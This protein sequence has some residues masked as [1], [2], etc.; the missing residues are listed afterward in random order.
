M[1]E[2]PRCKIDMKRIDFQAETVLPSGRTLPRLVWRCPC[3][4]MDTAPA[5]RP[6]VFPARQTVAAAYRSA[7]AAPAVVQLDLFADDPIPADF[8]RLLRSGSSP[9]LSAK[10]LTVLTVEQDALVRR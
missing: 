2:C 3:C 4:L 10:V 5:E 7:A 9:S 8:S 1:Q 6:Q